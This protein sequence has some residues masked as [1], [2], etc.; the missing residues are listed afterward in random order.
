LLASLVGAAVVPPASLAA[1]SWGLA[2]IAELTV[3]FVA[4]IP[5]VAPAVV[6]NSGSEPPDVPDAV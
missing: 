4:V 1:I 6:V 2:A 3:M 5:L